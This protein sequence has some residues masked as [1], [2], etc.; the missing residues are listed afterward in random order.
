MSRSRALVFGGTG[1]VGR[2]VLAGLAEARVETAFTWHT[3]ERLA[4]DLASRHSQREVRVDLA[5]PAATR[6]AIAT[7]ARDGFCPDLFIHCAAVNRTAPLA[8]L[9]DADWDEAQAVNCRSAFV[10][11]RELAA[12]MTASGEGHVVLV[13][14]LDRAQSLPAPAP[15]AASQGALAALAMALAKELGAGG[16]L[17]NMVALGILETGLSRGLEAGLLADFKGFSA[18]RRE[19]TPAEAARAILWLALENTYMSGKVLSV[20]GGI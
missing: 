7:L 14:A 18:L 17:V 9:T 16:V 19:G 13:G 20:N 6:E 3:S 8:R 4:S 10:A 11:C 1:A 12:G 2:E 15:F 5:S